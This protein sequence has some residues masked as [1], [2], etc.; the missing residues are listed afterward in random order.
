MKLTKELI[1]ELPLEQAAESICLHLFGD[2]HPSNLRYVPLMTD[3]TR[4][5]ARRGYVYGLGFD[6]LT[7]WAWFIPK[8]FHELCEGDFKKLRRYQSRA[9]GEVLWLAVFRAALLAVLYPSANTE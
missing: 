4:E 1:A 9:T 6:G 3:T 2:E 5:M 7:H 8:N